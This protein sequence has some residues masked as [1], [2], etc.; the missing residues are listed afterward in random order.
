MV[1]CDRNPIEKAK[2]KSKLPKTYKRAKKKPQE[3]NI[4][5]GSTVIIIT[6]SDLHA[7]SS[8]LE[9]ISFAL[10][11]LHQYVK[12]EQNSSHGKEV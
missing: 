10:L 9:P 1:A 3:S 8:Y 12:D 5:K 11:D 7:H 4:S 6:E 2:A